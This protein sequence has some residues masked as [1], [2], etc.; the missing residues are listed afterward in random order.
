[1][2]L[3]GAIGASRER[4]LGSEQI[5]INCEI[6]E[7]AGDKYYILKKIKIDQSHLQLFAERHS[8]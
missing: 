5:I 4:L 2:R 8:V 6:Q 3:A 7:L 1:M